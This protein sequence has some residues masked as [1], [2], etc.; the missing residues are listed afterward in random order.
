VSDDLAPHSVDLVRQALQV[1]VNEAGAEVNNG[2]WLVA[3]YVAVV[4]LFRVDQDGTAQTRPILVPMPDQ[5][6]YVT[7][8]LLGEAPDLLAFLAEVEE[9]EDADTED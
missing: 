4:G 1:H 9:A 5:A 8:G 6:A 3:H 7:N 2:G